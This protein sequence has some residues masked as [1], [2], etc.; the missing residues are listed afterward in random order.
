M[1]V[2]G[3]GRRRTRRSFSVPG[4]AR[5]ALRASRVPRVSAPPALVKGYLRAGAWVC[6]EPAWDPEFNT[7]D[8]FLL[9]PLANVA[10]RYAR[11]F[12]GTVPN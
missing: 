8:F 1:R 6:G 5:G 10:P 3:H 11:H 4:H 9:L 7:A 12:L 2:D